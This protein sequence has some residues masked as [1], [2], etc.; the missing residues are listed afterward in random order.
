MIA[1]NVDL[2]LQKHAGGGQPLRTDPDA[3]EARMQALYRIDRD[4]RVRTAHGNEAVQRLYREYLDQPL[5]TR[6]HELLH[7][8]YSRR[9]VV[10]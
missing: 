10:V 5:G 3:I 2:I 7:T 6:S 1:S 8:H 9:D 4:E